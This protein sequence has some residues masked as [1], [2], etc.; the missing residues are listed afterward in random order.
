MAAVPPPAFYRNPGEFIAAGADFVDWSSERELKNWKA[1]TKALD[2]KFDLK[3]ANLMTFLNR[4]QERATAFNWSAV[5]NVPIGDPPVNQNIIE[6]YGVITLEQCRAHATTYLA[7]Q[8]RPSQ[9]SAMLYTF[10][11]GSLTAEANNVLDLNPTS[12]TINGQVDGLCL[13]KQIIAKSFVDTN[14]TVSMIRRTIGKLDDKIKE[15][16]FDIKAF[17]HYVEMQVASLAA[18][19][20]K[21]DELIP[22]LF[23]SYLTVKDEEF[24]QL[25]RMHYFQHEQSNAVGNPT[26]IMKSIENHYHRRVAEGTWNPV[27]SKTDKERI[28]ALESTIAELRADKHKPTETIQERNN[29]RQKIDD[30]KW[31]WKQVAPKTGTPHTM[32]KNKKTYHWCV[33]HAMWTIHRPEECRLNQKQTITANVTVEEEKETEKKEKET[34][35]VD[36]AYQS[37]ISSGGRIF[38]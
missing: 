5:L 6:N 28:I 36:Q 9:V 26:S 25:V 35:Q 30:K 20:V 10:L 18:H 19:S 38:A 11:R 23:T 21:C 3:Q 24:L 8:T 16:K 22:N 1:A 27:I 15:Y 7:L 37:I 33:K 12:Y 17:N 32:E 34:V 29:K 2:T 13:L 14:S 4:I 31:A